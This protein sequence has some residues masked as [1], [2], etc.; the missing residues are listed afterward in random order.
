M[1]LA[2]LL[3]K[4]GHLTPASFGKTLPRTRRSSPMRG[5]QTGWSRTTACQIVFLATSRPPKAR[6]G[7]CLHSGLPITLIRD[8]DGSARDAC[9][10]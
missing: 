5:P 7:R 3:K 2:K 8:R 9:S 6:S 1:S 4:E 10:T